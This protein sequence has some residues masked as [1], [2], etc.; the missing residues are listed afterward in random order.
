M[1]KVRVSFS[2]SLDGF[3]AGPDQ[4]LQDPLGKGGMAMHEWALRDANLQADAWRGLGRLGRRRRR[5][6]RREHG[7]HGRLDPRPQHVRPGARAVARRFVER[8]VGRRPAVSRADVRSHPSRARA[9]RDEG[10]NDLR[11]RHRR[12]PCR[13]RA[14]PRRGRRQGRP[15]RRWRVDRAPVR[16][17]RPG[18]RDAP[19]DLE[20][21]ARRA[22]SISSPGSTCR[23]EVSPSPGAKPPSSPRTSCSRAPSPRPVM[24]VRP[25]ARGSRSHLPQA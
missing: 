23:R 11:L 1:A 24:Q 22:A 7:E 3:G 12:H 21:A 17:G 13:A 8:L 18:R 15:H 2:L 9:D 19:R 5:L 16:R 10:R 4:S 6:R 25:R 14:G 20:R